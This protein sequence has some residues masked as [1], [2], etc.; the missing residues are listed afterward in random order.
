MRRFYLLTAIILA[1]LA[2]IVGGIHYAGEA[3]SSSFTLLFTNPD[4]SPCQRPC[5]LGIRPGNMTF[6]AAIALLKT[7]PVTR[8]L[9]FQAVNYRMNQFK[10]RWLQVTV[11]KTPGGK[12]ASIGIQF[13]PSKFFPSESDDDTGL[14]VS[15]IRSAAFGD[16]VELLGAPDA[17]YTTASNDAVWSYYYTDRLIIQ[18]T[19]TSPENSSRRITVEDSVDFIN[20]VAN[21]Q[22][23]EVDSVS[24][25]FGFGGTGRYANL[26][27]A[28]SPFDP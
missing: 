23:Q 13:Y 27:D 15:P 7:H 9:D 16:V 17:V 26:S 5:M 19:L 10:G 21:R 11:L 28:L 22:F 4:G 6:E 18:T 12:V 14:P 1:V 20:L 25:W 24:Q 3:R 8:N 2:A